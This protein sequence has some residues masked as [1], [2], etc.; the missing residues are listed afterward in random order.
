MYVEAGL[1]LL[2]MLTMC[3]PVGVSWSLFDGRGVKPAVDGVCSELQN[4][5]G[6][7]AVALHLQQC[8][9]LVQVDVAQRLFGM[10]VLVQN[11]VF[12]ELS[13]RQP[14]PLA[15]L[16]ASTSGDDTGRQVVDWLERSGAAGAPIVALVKRV[17][18]HK[19]DKKFLPLYADAAGTCVQ[20][21]SVIER[22]QADRDFAL[23]RDSLKPLGH[24]RLW[25]ADCVAWIGGQ[26]EALIVR[27]RISN[28]AARLLPADDEFTATSTISQ[29][30]TLLW[31]CTVRRCSLTRTRLRCDRG[32]C[33]KST[34]TSQQ[35]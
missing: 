15:A 16:A 18:C 27:K 5:D 10:H 32:F 4:E 26:Q 33:P 3:P 22:R 24:M 12:A 11:A 6:L 14:V 7:C 13:S 31:A 23:S 8:T 25:A 19:P 35:A 28:D 20:V 9:S 30:R 2:G 17:C 34:R 21:L 1:Q 29:R